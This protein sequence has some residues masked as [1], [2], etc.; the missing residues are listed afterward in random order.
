MRPYL[1]VFIQ[2][3]SWTIA[4]VFLYAMDSDS[5]SSSL[6]LFR[7]MGFENCPGCG[8]GHA[9][10]EALHL[11]FSKSVEA[12]IMGIPAA[13]TLIFFIIRTFISSIKQIRHGSET[14]NDV[15]QSST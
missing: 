8:L 13:F 9:I 14:A 10:R 3:L 7:F 5:V 6:C 2:P 15:A 4:L 11:N 1:I 12:H